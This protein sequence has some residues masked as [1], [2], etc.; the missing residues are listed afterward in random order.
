[1]RNK[2]LNRGTTCV[3]GASLLL[4][5]SVA[6]GTA[7]E[8]PG[9]TREAV[10]SRIEKE[11]PDLFELY[12]QLHSHPELSF[13]EVQTSARMAEELRKA[14]FEVTTGVGKYGVVGVLH[15]G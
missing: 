7:A 6:A 8:L 2:L 13:Q 9:V 5:G 4:I 14:G 11:Y 12:K 1:M 3:L 10:Q 15:N